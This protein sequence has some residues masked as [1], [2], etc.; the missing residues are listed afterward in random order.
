MAPRE[1]RRTRPSLL[2]WIGALAAM[3]LATAPSYAVAA[4]PFPSRAPVGSDGAGAVCPP[5]HGGPWCLPRLCGP[6]CSPA[7]CPDGLPGCDGPGSPATGEVTVIKED[8]NTGNPLAGAVFQM[9]EETNGIPGLQTTGADP[10]TGIGGPC[11][12]GADG[13]CSLTVTPGVYYWL[14]T[15]APPG[16]ELPLDPV[17]GPLVLR[18]E[19]IGEGVTVIAENQPESDPPDA[20]PSDRTG[21]PPHS[22]SH[23]ANG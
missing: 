22:A 13:A 8:A 14:E 1:L 19:S 20:R 21:P 11:T 12:T 9:W 4:E 16:Y 7:H 18:Q 10:D 3:L 23:S 17:F 2:P 6:W 5:G 15:Q